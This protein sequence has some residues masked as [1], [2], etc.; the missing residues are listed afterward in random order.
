MWI[1]NLDWV[2]NVY[3]PDVRHILDDRLKVRRRVVR[4]GDEDVVVC[5]VRSGRVQRG[6]ADESTGQL[7]LVEGEGGTEAAGS[8]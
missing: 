8:E 7:L 6:D 2:G 5:A 1:L 3:V 4:L